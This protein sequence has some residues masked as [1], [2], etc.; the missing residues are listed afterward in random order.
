VD[1]SITGPEVFVDTNVMG[2]LVLLRQAQTAGIRRFLQVSTDEV[3]GSLGEN[4]SFR[5]DSPIQPN[6][7]Y[8]ASKTGAD[9]LVR[10]FHHTYGMDT[11]ICRCSNNYGPFQFPE[12]MIPLMINNASRNLP[13]PVYGDGLN[14]RDWLYVSDHCSALWAAFSQGRAGEVYNIGGDSERTNLEVIRCILRQ[15][16]KPESLIQFV[17]DRPGHDRRYA[18]D[19]T[20]IKTELGW[21]AEVDFNSGIARTVQWYTDNQKWLTTITSGA[22]QHYYEEMYGHRG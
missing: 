4:G 17:K 12:K 22:Y 14:V 6:S 3:Y 8:S 1:R 9:H 18:M 13:L 16:G 11:I 19:A 2:T 21:R 5:E 10:A 7:P 20:K 15:L